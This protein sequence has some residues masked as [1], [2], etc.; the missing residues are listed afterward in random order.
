M[1]SIGSGQ[2]PGGSFDVPE[3]LA[4]KVSGLPLGG[5][6]DAPDLL[7]AKAR[8]ENFPVASHLLPRR[9]RASLMAIYGFARLTDDLGDEAEGDRLAMLDW[10]EAD[11][12]RAAVGKATNPVL[13]QLSPVI[14]ELHLS[15]DPFRDLIEANR[16]D[17]T[18]TR[19][20]SFEDL[21]GYCML[22][23][24]PVGRLV[25]AVFGVSTPERVELSDK[26]CIALQVVEHLQDIGEDAARG[27]VYM[28]VEDLRRFGCGEAD[29]RAEHASSKLREMVAMQSARARDLLGAGVLLAATLRLR[30]RAAVVGFAAGGLAAL[31]A[32][33]QGHYDVLGTRCRPRKARFASRALSGLV[34]ASLRRGRS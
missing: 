9:S 14:E 33:E 23:A 15:L 17:Q 20:E 21:L 5:E 26:V 27:R 31:D 7:A 29:L 22:S 4:T 6:F 3:R 10:L 11:L 25:L 24:A 12:E 13:S 30:P 28:P 16:M 8:K 18:V 19:Y 1:V 32:I 2:S 34:S